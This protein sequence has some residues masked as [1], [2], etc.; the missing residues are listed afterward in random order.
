MKMMKD[1]LFQMISQ[2]I[3]IYLKS[4]KILIQRN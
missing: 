1:L 4:I 2:T 3:R